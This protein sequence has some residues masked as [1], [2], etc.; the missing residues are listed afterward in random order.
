MSNVKDDGPGLAERYDRVSNSQ[1]ERGLLLAERMGIKENDAVLDIGCGT[2][3]LALQLSEKVG[4]SGSIAGIDP[5]PHRVEI[6][7][8]KL[9]S[10]ALQNVRFAVGAAEDLHGF[11]DCSF[12][13]A[14]YSSVF[15]WIEDKATALKEA[16]RILKP[17]GKVGMTTIDRNNPLS[18]RAIAIKVLSKPSY[19]GLLTRRSDVTRPVGEKELEL[20]FT[21][22]GFQDISIE[23]LTKKGHY[24]SAKNF[25]EFYE[26][27][28]FG[29]FLGN[30]PESIRPAV[31]SDMEHELESRRTPAGIELVTN[32]I[33]A[34]AVKPR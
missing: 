25:L 15:H 4:P 18:V 12:D 16:Y 24:Q 30:V 10:I 9:K 29:N 19:K 28:S 1:F 7:N 3:R 21:D 2:G 8:E 13:Q 6:A 26:A 33:L 14:Y 23:I 27:S 31:W 20:L 22:A 34:T 32:T 11:S 5:A 17:G